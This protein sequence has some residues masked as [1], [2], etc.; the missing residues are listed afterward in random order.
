MCRTGYAKPF[1]F[2]C[3]SPNTEQ[4]SSTAL[5]VATGREPQ[6]GSSVRRDC[7]PIGRV[8]IL[9]VTGEHHGRQHSAD[10][11]HYVN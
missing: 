3:L 4:Y 1:R 6:S 11:I 7:V 10:K 8:A 9:E 2:G 5:L